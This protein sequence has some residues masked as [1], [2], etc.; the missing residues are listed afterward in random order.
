MMTLLP[1]L[2]FSDN[3]IWIIKEK[4]RP[5]VWAVDPGDAKVVSEYCQNESF[6]LSGILLT[7]HHKDHTGGVAELKRQYQ[8]PVYGP[9]HLKDLVTHPMHEGDRVTIFSREFIVLETPGHTL[10]HLC[11]F[12]ESQPPI[13]LCGDTLFR[14]GCGRIMEG[15]AEQMLGAMNKLAE[16]PDDTK[17]YCTH[18]YTLANY[19]F[20]EHLDPTNQKLTTARKDCEIKRG[21][22]NVTLPSTMGL[23]K[24]T[25]PFLRTDFTHIIEKAAL[26][27][28]EE[29]ATQPSSAFS[30][31]RR[32][33][34]TFG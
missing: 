5:Q 2:A 4:D 22:N 23:E 15:T 18:E 32:A 34:D 24:E 20:A 8:C 13:L 7:H 25:N 6:T 9:E 11:Y 3:Y 27:L 33:K 1:L 16:L 26:Q 31:V 21:N 10:D 29:I 14:G 12:S 28:G 19:R 17:V 30:Q